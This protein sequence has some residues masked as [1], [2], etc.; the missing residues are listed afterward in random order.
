MNND[1][2][3]EFLLELTQESAMELIKI[4]RQRS[5]TTTQMVI[6]KFRNGKLRIS[7]QEFRF[8]LTNMFE[9]F[10]L[11]GLS[12]SVET[13]T[14]GLYSFSKKGE[15][16]ASSDLSFYYGG[17]K[18]LNIE[19]KSHNPSYY[20]IE[21]D[22]EKLIKEPNCGAWLHI[23]ENENSKTI[24]RL[25]DKFCLSLKNLKS[26][27]KYPISFH[28]LILKPEILISRKGQDD[29]IQSFNPGNLFNTRRSSWIDLDPGKHLIQNGWQ[30][31]KFNV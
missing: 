8:T 14:E 26:E 29:D 7:E 30:I 2:I 31:D 25:F 5:D 21:K 19:F 1:R 4:Y 16:S 12:Y 6:P 27:I 23:F 9:K 17:K 24:E 22:I 13:P 10:P 3:F 18:V 28:I 20:S 11:S 15:R